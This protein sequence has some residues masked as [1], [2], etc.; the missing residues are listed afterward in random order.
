VNICQRNG[1]DSVVFERE[2]DELIYK[3]Y[4]ITAEEQKIIEGQ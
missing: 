1:K 3:L 2:I 4:D